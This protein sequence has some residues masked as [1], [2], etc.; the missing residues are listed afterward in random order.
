VQFPDAYLSL[1]QPKMFFFISPSHIAAPPA[2][3]LPNHIASGVPIVA[4]APIIFMIPMLTQASAATRVNEQGLI[5]VV[6]ADI[7]RF[8]HDPVTLAPK[9]VLIE[10]A[11]TN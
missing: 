1:L 8:D 4:P 2:K 5:E 11:T 7:S 3:A 6:P 10:A 9:G